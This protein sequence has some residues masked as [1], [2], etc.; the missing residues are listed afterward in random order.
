M[1]HVQKFGKWLIFG[2]AVTLLIAK[3]V[4][5]YGLARQTVIFSTFA[6]FTL[7][8]ALFVAT[9]LVLVFS[10]FTQRALV[11][12]IMFLVFFGLAE[13]VVLLTGGI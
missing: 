9:G 6:A 5:H 1:N 7:L 2:S 8:V 11:L 12:F 10:A 13:Y 4:V 3:I